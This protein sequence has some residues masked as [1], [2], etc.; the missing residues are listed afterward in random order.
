MARFFFFFQVM[1]VFAKHCDPSSTDLER[2]AWASILQHLPKETVRAA[3]PLAIK[4]EIQQQVVRGVKEKQFSK[5]K[6]LAIRIY[7]GLSWEKIG[8]IRNLLGREYD[9][10]TDTYKPFFIPGTNI[11]A[12]TFACLT[13]LK[14]EAAKHLENL[15]LNLRY[16]DE[17]RLC[18]AVAVRESVAF[19]LDRLLHQ[20]LL[21]NVTRIT[22]QLK[23]DG[24]SSFRGIS[25][26][27]LG[28]SCPS[29]LSVAESPNWYETLALY[30]GTDHR[31]NLEEH[32]KRLAEEIKKVENVSVKGKT[33]ALDWKLGGDLPFISAERGLVGH[34]GD[35]PCPLCRVHK[36][37]LDNL[38]APLRTNEEFWE[39][40]HL[41][42]GN[43]DQFVCEC[44]DE[45]IDESTPVPSAA[46][47]A[48]HAALHFGHHYGQAPIF[49]FVNIGDVHFDPLHGELRISGYLWKLTVAAN[50]I[51]EELADKITSILRSHGVH[52]RQQKKSSNVADRRTEESTSFIGALARLLACYF[53]AL[54]ENMADRAVAGRDCPKLCKLLPQVLDLL[55]PAN[56]RAVSTLFSF[57]VGLRRFLILGSRLSIADRRN[58]AS[59]GNHHVAFAQASE[60]LAEATES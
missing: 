5:E 1:A 18:A 59:V 14:K 30:R 7:C 46:A 8:T 29:I 9:V 58:L 13:T 27:C 51:S 60:P 20:R 33:F 36:D 16:V 41:L 3:L 28:F 56:R 43:V 38:S 55:K 35:Y 57:D 39:L 15:G 6:A 19:Y 22:L 47:Q 4:Q 52:V 24:Y 54:Q 10:E 45:K 17:Q 31:T 34:S 48:R 32:G 40:S 2:S 37:D 42:H 21:N 44:C 11:K 26:T 23:G 12:E 25:E 50:I 49:D 53:L